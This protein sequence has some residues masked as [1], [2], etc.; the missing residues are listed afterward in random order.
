L[1]FHVSTLQVEAVGNSTRALII[2][3][4][5]ITDLTAE[6][7]AELVSEIGRLW[8]ERHQARLAA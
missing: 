8:Q 7:I 5:R 4:R 6:G 1:K 2:S 3:N